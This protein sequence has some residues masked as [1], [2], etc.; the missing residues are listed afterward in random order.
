MVVHELCMWLTKQMGIIL[1]LDTGVGIIKS[2][3]GL[4]EVVLEVHCKV[5]SLL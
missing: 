3:D 5:I 1:L 4:V 2:P